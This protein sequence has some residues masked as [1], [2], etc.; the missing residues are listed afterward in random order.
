VR[1]ALVPG[2]RLAGPT[3]AERTPLPYFT[4]VKG[5]AASIERGLRQDATDSGVP[6]RVISELADIFGWEMDLESELH[7]GDEFRVLYENI[8]QA[9]EARAEPGKVLGAGSVAKG[10]TRTPV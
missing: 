1:R 8:W 4:E 7:P 9:G 3:R 10:R 5:L 6:A 2:R